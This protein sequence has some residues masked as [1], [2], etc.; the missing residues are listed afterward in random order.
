MLQIP[1]NF[2]GLKE[3]KTNHIVWVNKAPFIAQFG[4]PT[5]EGSLLEEVS[6]DFGVGAL[7]PQEI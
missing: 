2:K 1:F 7:I 3:L 6:I 4:L 5:R